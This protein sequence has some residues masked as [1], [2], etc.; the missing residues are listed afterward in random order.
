MRANILSSFLSGFAALQEFIY[1]HLAGL[2]RTYYKPH[3]YVILLR[4]FAGKTLVKL[5]ITAERHDLYG[6]P[7]KG[8]L[9][10]D[11]RGFSALKCIRIDEDLFEVPETCIRK[12]DDGNKMARL[13]DML[14]K[15]TVVLEILQHRVIAE[16]TDLFKDLAE[17]KKE[18][19]PGMRAISC[20]HKRFDSPLTGSL[21]ESLERVGLRTY[22][23][24][25]STT[26][27]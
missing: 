15:S 16:A 3:E 6:T 11:L 24:P 23:T 13:V 20:W 9:Y 5:D 27:I 7:V 19:L 22:T 8:H 12:H 14:P 17:L 4:Q 2:D 25:F 10:V 18:R 1:H 21:T 26:D